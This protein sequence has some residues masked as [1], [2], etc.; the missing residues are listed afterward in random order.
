LVAI[1]QYLPALPDETFVN[2]S[3]VLVA[4]GSEPPLKNHW[5]FSGALFIAW[6]EK[7]TVLPT[8]LITP[9]GCKSKKGNCAK[10]P[11]NK[12]FVRT[13]SDTG[14]VLLFVPPD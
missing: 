11:V 13:V 14:L 4:P 5:Y 9:T 10:V 1:I 7:F 12:R 6:A 3:V 2:V 8:V